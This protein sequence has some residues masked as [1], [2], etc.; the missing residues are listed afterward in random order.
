MKIK[1]SWIPFIPVAILSIFLRI[2]QKL[3]VDSGIDT[4]FLSSDMIWLVYAGLVGALF[5]VLLFL[6][7]ID[8]KTSL[9]YKIKANFFAGLFAVAASALLIFD[10][11]MRAAQMLSSG[12]ERVTQPLDVIFSLLGGI[13]ILVMGISSFSG[14]NL[15]K[16]LGVFSV[17]APVWCCVKLVFT[18]AEYTKQSVNSF[19]MTNLFFMA[20]ITM[21]IFNLSMTYQGVDCK[22]PIKGTIVYGMPAFIVTIVYAVANAIDQLRA[23]GAYDLMNSLDTIIY[24]ALAFYILFMMIEFTVNARDKKDEVVVEVEEYEEQ[25]TV[26]KKNEIEEEATKKENNHTE[27]SDVEE[28]VSKDLNGVDNVI[29]AMEQEEKNPE[30]YNPR[31]KE[32]FDS[33]ASDE[34]SEDDEISKS[35]ANID[36]L[37][38]EIGME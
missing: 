21:A 6:S 25:P 15:A 11:G 2:Y 20:F 9:H 37:I 30:K 38:N 31:S 36:K 33:H 18:F 1:F 8:K 7:A 22:N 12:F 32:F 3:F 28:N 34:I 4:G 19:D 29:D 17:F 24:T 14:K 5:V 23:L 26:R 13:V 27:I 35:M 10:S 16:K